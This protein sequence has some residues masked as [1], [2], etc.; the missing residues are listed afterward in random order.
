MRDFYIRLL[1]MRLNVS[2]IREVAI[3]MKFVECA[4]GNKRN[5]GPAGNL[6]AETAKTLELQSVRLRLSALEQNQYRMP[7]TAVVRM[8]FLS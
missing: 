4:A 5:Q 2:Y 1:D 6:L 8:S 7:S 3:T